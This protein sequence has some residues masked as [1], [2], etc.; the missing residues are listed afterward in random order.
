MERRRRRVP[1]TELRVHLGE[2][3]RALEDEDLVIEKGGVPVA[4]LT[5][6]DGVIYEIGREARMSRAYTAALTKRGNPEAWP[7]AFVAMARGWAGIE[8]EA[9]T[10]RV[11]AARAAGATSV[12]YTLDEEGA[13][14]GEVPSGQRRLYWSDG[15]TRRVADAPDRGDSG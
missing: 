7:G 6:Y 4:L 10:E 8:A 3:L 12:H 1:A 15:E 11:Y 14:D 13:G 9:L 2:A 5:R